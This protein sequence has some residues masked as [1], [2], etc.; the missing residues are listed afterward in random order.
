MEPSE[1][2]DSKPVIKQM[3]RFT[4]MQ[5]TQM[6]IAE[7]DSN[8]EQFKSVFDIKLHVLAKLDIPLTQQMICLD[9][10]ILQDNTEINLLC[11]Q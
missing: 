9:N 10:L 7:S 5:G 1:Q 3:P 6:I 11:P 2:I 8:I 4:L